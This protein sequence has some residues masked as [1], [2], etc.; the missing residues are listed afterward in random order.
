[1]SNFPY[2][3]FFKHHEKTFNF[4]SCPCGD[5]FTLDGELLCSRNKEKIKNL[6]RN[7]YYTRCEYMRL[8]KKIDWKAIKDGANG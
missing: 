1:M 3:D 8:E 6:S 4:G 2:C 5:S 7:G